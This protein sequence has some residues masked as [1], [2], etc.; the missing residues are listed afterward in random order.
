MDFL[1][2]HELSRELNKPERQLR[3]KF[4]NLLKK[5]TL[6]EGED[7]IRE[8]YIDD[9]HFVFKINPI[10][11]VALTQLN[12]APLPDTTGYHVDNNFDNKGSQ[13]GTNTV[14]NVVTNP[15]QLDTTVSA[16]QQISD[17]Q[18]AHETPN[19]S[20]TTDF[21]ELLKEQLREKDKQLKEKDDQ[22]KSK[23]DLLK[24]ALEQSK[25]KDSTQYLAM[26]EIIRLNKRLLP[27]SPGESVI[28]VDTN[29]YQPSNPLDN[30]S[31]N[32]AA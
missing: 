6:I 16:H 14:N 23:D 29:G 5:N 26:S 3:H 21:I 11:F 13:V 25:E 7:F 18:P 10:R 24:Q 17:T 30:N 8:G 20:V 31:G 32:Q 15:P 9:Q 28:E 27:P 2:L 4:K 1:T 22:L 19:T 12:P